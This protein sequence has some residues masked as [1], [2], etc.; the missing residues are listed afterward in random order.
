MPIIMPRMTSRTTRTMS[1][2]SNTPFDFD[3]CDTTLAVNVSSCLLS[4]DATVAT[5]ECAPD[6]AS[7]LTCTL[8]KMVCV[9]PAGTTSM[10]VGVIVTAAQSVLGTV[11][12][13]VLLVLPAFVTVIGNIAVCPFATLCI[14]LPRVMLDVCLLSSLQVSSSSTVIVLFSLTFLCLCENSTSTFTSYWPALAHFGTLMKIS[15]VSS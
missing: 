9:W 8:T 1:I 2:T 13:N 4:P 6:G 7:S 10:L 5:S 11:T 3:F 12:T 15:S 14:W